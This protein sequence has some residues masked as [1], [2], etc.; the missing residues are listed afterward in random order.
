MKFSRDN[1]KLALIFIFIVVMIWL[2]FSPVQLG[3]LTSY[4]VINGNSMEPDF[5]VGDLIV[6]RKSPSYKI[7]QPVVY[8]NPKVGFVFHRIIDQEGSQYILAGDNNDWIDSYHPESSEIIGKLWFSI[9]GGGT[10]ITKLR[11]PLYFALFS[12]IILVILVSILFGKKDLQLF[13]KKGKYKFKMKKEK[14]T[15]SRESRQDLLLF[16]AVVGIAALV[17]GFISHTRPLTRLVTDE[18][19]F[20]HQG[21][22]KYYAPDQ[23]GIYDS[24][25]IQTGDPVYS[26]LNC[27]L[28]L[29]FNYQFS[30]PNMTDVESDAFSGSYLIYAEVSDLDG[31]KRSFSLVPETDFSGSKAET[32]MLLDICRVQS[33]FIE[34]EQKTATDSRQYNLSIFPRVSVSGSVSDIPIAEVYRPEI[35]FQVDKQKM[36]LMD[37]VEGLKLDQDGS[38]LKPREVRNYL[39]IFGQ[40]FSIGAARKV[41]LIML[42]IAILGAIIPIRSLFLDLRASDQSRIQVQYHSLLLNVE[43]G[44]AKTKTSHVVQVS[45]FQDLVRMSESYGTMILHESRGKTHHY[46]IQDEGTLYRYSMVE[47]KPPEE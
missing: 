10:V 32:W 33:L 6:A 44:S 37:G 42:G 11:E 47:P 19:P 20:L 18:L 28:D 43:K 34:K 25:G 4:V 16:L 14:F 27:I 46:S 7:N 17:L 8:D 45:S 5:M 9:S 40:A 12:L 39:H 2:I 22:L 30:A 38:L 24:S 31:W 29:E 26:Q 23:S 41:S 1:T 13:T 15:L 3:G 21:D 35:S 36:R